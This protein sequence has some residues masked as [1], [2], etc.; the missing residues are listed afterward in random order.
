MLD[1]ILFLKSV[2]LFQALTLE[3]IAHLAEPAE[4]ASFAAGQVVFEA[5]GPVKHFAVIRSGTVELRIHDVAVDTITC[6]ASFGE[7]AFLED[8]RHAVSG[9]AVTDLIVLRFHRR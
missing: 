2:P 8:A 9:T 6:G 5:G 7:N 3:E 4:T 1:L